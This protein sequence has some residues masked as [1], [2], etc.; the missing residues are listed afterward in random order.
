LVRQDIDRVN[1]TVPAGARVKK[2]IN[3]HKELDPDEGELTRTRNL[4][5]AF[6]EERYRKLMDAMYRDN[7]TVPIDARD[8]N[9]DG[10]TGTIETSLRIQFVEGAG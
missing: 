9:R 8:G 6:L 7:D 2:Y 5:R 3:L 4:K 1:Q 10:R